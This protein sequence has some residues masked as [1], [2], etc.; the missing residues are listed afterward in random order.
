MSVCMR[1]RLHP[2]SSSAPERPQ[3][4]RDT[5][6]R[7]SSQ[8]RASQRRL[9]VPINLN[10]ITHLNPSGLVKGS[11]SCHSS[12]E[13]AIRNIH[14]TKAIY[15]DVARIPPSEQKLTRIHTPVR[16]LRALRPI[17]L[18]Q[19]LRRLLRI[20]PIRQMRHTINPILTNRIT[21]STELLHLATTKLANRLSL[22]R[23]TKEHRTSNLVCA[24]L[25][26]RIVHDHRTLRI[27]AQQDCRLRALAQ[28]LLD[29]FHH[30]GTAAGA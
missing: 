22:E 7:D 24:K 15:Q 11:L 9:L 30:D 26:R 29:E 4:P 3:K 25:I 5:R 10:F 19:K 16:D 23:I 18:N 13:L 12:T 1:L 14:S 17:N 20:A 28:S 21:D 6:S 2:S 8:K 27:S